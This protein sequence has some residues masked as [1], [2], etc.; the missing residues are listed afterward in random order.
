M[1]LTSRRTRCPLLLV[2]AS[3]VKGANMSLSNGKIFELFSEAFPDETAQTGQRLRKRQVEI[4][5]AIA[6]EL[7]QRATGVAALR[8][9][10]EP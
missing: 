9:S 3:L 4:V 2:S 7:K 6:L 5:N 1:A 10:A 8:R